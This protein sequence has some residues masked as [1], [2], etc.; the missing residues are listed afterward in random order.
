MIIY[1]C[2]FHQDYFVVSLAL[3]STTYVND[4]FQNSSGGNTVELCSFD[5]FL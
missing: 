4:I 3:F 2:V 1:K 5:K